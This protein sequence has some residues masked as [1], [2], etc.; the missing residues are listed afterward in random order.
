MGT[1]SAAESLPRPPRQARS[2]RV[3]ASSI[4][5]V[6]CLRSLPKPYSRVSRTRS[7]RRNLFCKL[8]HTT[9]PRRRRTWQGERTSTSGVPERPSPG[10]GAS[11]SA[12]VSSWR[13]TTPT[14]TSG[15]RLQGQM[16]SC[17]TGGRPT[18]A[19]PS[20]PPGSSTASTIESRRAAPFASR[21]PWRRPAAPSA[22]RQSCSREAS[23]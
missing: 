6:G 1:D 21:P 3:L 20:S 12:R 9:H 23:V 11:V 5:N 10:A 18:P 4:Q 14:S 8:Y 2:E 15:S 7:N 13:T 17:S 16:K 22:A 19:R